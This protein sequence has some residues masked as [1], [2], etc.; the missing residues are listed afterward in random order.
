MTDLAG[1]EDICG[2]ARGEAE[3]HHSEKQQ[4]L[5]EHEL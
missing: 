1:Q 5:V 4:G 3:V 2:S